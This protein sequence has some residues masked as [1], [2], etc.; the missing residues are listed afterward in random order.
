MLASRSWP[1]S[2]VRLH[3]R[4]GIHGVKVAKVRTTR[5]SIYQLRLCSVIEIREVLLASASQSCRGLIVAKVD[6]MQDRRIWSSG[7]TLRAKDTW[8]KS[9]S[10]EQRSKFPSEHICKFRE[11]KGIMQGEYDDSSETRTSFL[12]TFTSRQQPTIRYRPTRHI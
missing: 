4:Q 11:S 8:E 7:S 6:R 5:S 12:P 1:S 3:Q 10:G 2:D 9:C